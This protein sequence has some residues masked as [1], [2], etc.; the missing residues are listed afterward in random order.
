MGNLHCL[1]LG[2]LS[3]RA[4]DSSLRKTG[5]APDFVHLRFSP[6][7]AVDGGSSDPGIAVC[8]SRLMFTYLEPSVGIVFFEKVLSTVTRS[9]R[10]L[11]LWEPS[12]PQNEG[13]STS[14]GIMVSWLLITTTKSAS[15][16]L[17]RE[18]WWPSSFYYIRKWQTQHSARVWTHQQFLCTGSI[19]DSP[20]S[21][22][23]KPRPC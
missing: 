7:W 3:V 8:Y 12:A 1:Y 19:S 16:A 10:I 14:Q 9:W 23:Y 20:L 17:I 11:Y 5:K 6:C 15:H 21:S 2:A 4:L 22:D 18:T 13:I